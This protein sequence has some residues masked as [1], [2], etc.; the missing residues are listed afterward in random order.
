MSCYCLWVTL[1][2]CQSSACGSGCSFPRHNVT[3]LVAMVSC[4]M[5]SLWNGRGAAVL[6]TRRRRICI[7][8]WFGCAPLLLQQEESHCFKR[9]E[10]GG[11]SAFERT[12]T[13]T[14]NTKAAGRPLTFFSLSL[15]SFFSRSSLYSH[16]QLPFT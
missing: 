3:A 10:V 11:Q 6:S 16:L 2:T 8:A 15:F 4:S 9:V 7:T 12:K 13:S 5:P 1:V 14:R